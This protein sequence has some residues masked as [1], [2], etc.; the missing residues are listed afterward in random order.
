MISTYAILET[1][2][3]KVKN[4]VN[5]LLVVEMFIVKSVPENG[6]FPSFLRPISAPL[7]LIDSKGGKKCI[8]WVEIK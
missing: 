6:Y 2:Q 3:M 4:I 7:L 1:L 5:M 8:Y